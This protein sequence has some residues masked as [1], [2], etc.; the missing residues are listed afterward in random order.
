MFTIVIQIDDSGQFIDVQFENP[1]M[2]IP[3]EVKEQI[4]HDVDT[5]FE[6]EE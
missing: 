5:E 2:H 4:I 6:E 3:I 1:P